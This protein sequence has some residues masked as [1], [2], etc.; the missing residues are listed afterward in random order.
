M[1]D[2]HILVLGGTGHLGSNLIHHLVN[3]LGVPPA[4]IR[5]F[6]LKGS[7]AQ[8]LEDI[9][10]LDMFE[11]NVLNKDDVTRACESVQIIFHL[12]G[13]T[14]FN[15]QLKKLQWQINVEGTRHVLEAAKESKSFEKMCY[16]ST[17]N[18]LAPKQP[19]GSIGSIEECDPYETS[20]RVH[21]F[22]S[23]EETLSFIETAKNAADDSWVKKIDIGYYDSKLAAQE[24]I[25]FYVK[26]YGLNAVSILPGT[27]F[28][29]YDQLIGTGMYIISIYHGEM[30]ATMPAGLPFTHIMDV[31]EGMVKAIDNGRKGE[32]YILSGKAED[33]RTLKDMAAIITEELQ[34]YFPDKK[35]RAPKLVLPYGPVYVFAWIY[36]RVAGLLN[37]NPVLNTQAVKAGNHYWYFSHEKSDKELGYAAKRTFREGVRDTIAYYDKHKLLD[38]RERYIDKK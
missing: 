29:A 12:I 33:N 5:V 23:A 7:P 28:G 20:H 35:F 36:E 38:V 9:V 21:S 34:R 3:D 32:M 4:H 19:R 2:K 22:N 26:S 18:V 24:L 14:T 37:L 8:S 1:K 13:S 11:G 16:V 27:M 30:P 25:N 6:Y 10:G 31:A 15:P 17:V